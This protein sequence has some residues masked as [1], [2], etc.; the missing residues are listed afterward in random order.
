MRKTKTIEVNLEDE[1][2]ES[3]LLTVLEDQAKSMA[4]QIE[5]T[6]AKL[7]SGW[8]CWQD[9]FDEIKIF[10]ALQEALNYNSYEHTMT[11]FFPFGNKEDQTEEEP[12][13]K[14]RKK[15]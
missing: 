9:L 15:K 12:K 13:K 2:V 10:N 4:K 7:S 3:L 1:L 11:P 6:V 8:N 14:R 5:D